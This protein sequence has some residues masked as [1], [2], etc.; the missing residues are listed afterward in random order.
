MHAVLCLDTV[1]AD[2]VMTLLVPH[3]LLLMLVVGSGI[4]CS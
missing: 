2:G 3:L 1:P 4:L